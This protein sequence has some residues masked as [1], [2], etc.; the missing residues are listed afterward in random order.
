MLDDRP[1]VDS[2]HD[3]YVFLHSALA[4]RHINRGAMQMLIALFVSA[5]IT[6][7]IFE[8]VEPDADSPEGI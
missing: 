6:F 8:C 7:V 5:V 3:S 1:A 4:L 2:T